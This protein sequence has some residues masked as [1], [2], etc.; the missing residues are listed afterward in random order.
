MLKDPLLASV[1]GIP[2][3]EHNGLL[4][5]DPMAFTITRP[6]TPWPAGLGWPCGSLNP[7]SGA[8][9]RGIQVCAGAG[10]WPSKCLRSRIGSGAVAFPCPSSSVTAAPV[11]PAYLL[12]CSCMFACPAMS[13]LTGCAEA[14]G[15]EQN[16]KDCV[17][18]GAVK[19]AMYY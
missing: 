4:D 14:P 18:T 9:R 3:R 5:G 19:L 2:R 15:K 6:K 17:F 12:P 1:W 7:P 11:T 13:S 8:S 10:L 16:C